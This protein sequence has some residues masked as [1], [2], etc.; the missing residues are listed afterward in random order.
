MDKI[1][2][3]GVSCLDMLVGPVTPALFEVDSTPVSIESFPGGDACNVALNTAALG[4]RPLLVS[5]VGEDPQGAWIRD[6]LDRHGVDTAGLA[7]SKDCGT[8][9]SLV[10]TAPDGERHFLTSTEVFRDIS[11][12]CITD[13]RLK[14]ARFLSLN[15]FYRGAQLDGGS[16]AALFH[17]AHA[18]GVRTVVDTLRCRTGDP[19]AQIAPV[20][21]ETDFFLPSYDEAVQI[22]GKKEPREMAEVLRPFGTRVFIVKL[23]SRG[24]FCMDYEK[25]EAC[26][27]PAVPAAY[28]VSTVGAGDAFC[29]GLIAALLR[30]KG[31]RE[32]LCFA[33]AAA[34]MT[35]QVNHA[36][37]AFSSFEEVENYARAAQE[38]L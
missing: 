10:M 7:A 20:L 15:S 6:Y 21:S 19:L 26:E 38:N 17:R 3:L 12:A 1:I 34:S 22:T 5:A 13:E 4:V 28:P 9:V 14:E 35:V 24:C 31:L 32:S 36:T 11:P 25:D 30:G 29:S 37:G 16:V 33:S 18:L 23:G 8:A 2:V 27:I